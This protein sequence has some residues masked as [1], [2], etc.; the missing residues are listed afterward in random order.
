MSCRHSDAF[1]ETPLPAINQYV[2]PAMCR[3]HD[4]V[5]RRSVYALTRRQE[6]KC[7]VEKKTRFVSNDGN[8]L[9]PDMETY[10]PKARRGAINDVAVCYETNR[11]SFS[12]VSRARIRRYQPLGKVIAKNNNLD[13]EDLICHAAVV[14]SRCLATMELLETLR[15]Y[16]L[17]KKTASKMC[18]TAAEQSISVFNYCQQRSGANVDRR[19]QEVERVERVRVCLECDRSE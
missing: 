7:V 16:E 18:F 10:F 9:I 11:D 15:Y 17:G 8:V 5:Q 3:R 2:K 1:K 14:G 4:A 13:V 19:V 12:E 6:G